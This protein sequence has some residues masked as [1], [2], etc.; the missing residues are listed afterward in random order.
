MKKTKFHEAKPLLGKLSDKEISL[1][2]DVDT[3]TVVRWRKKLNIKSTGI[4]F[5][6]SQSMTDKLKADKYFL[7]LLGNKPDNSIAKKFKVS[8]TLIMMIRNELNIKPYKKITK[9]QL[10]KTLDET[11]KE[12]IERKTDYKP[13]SYYDINCGWCA[14]FA[15]VVREKLNHSYQIRILADDDMNPDVEYSHT[16]IE[17]NDQYFDAECIEGVDDWTQLPTFHRN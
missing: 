1:T 14:D 15:T 16:F 10:I 8:H 2:F 3:S 9:K 4:R 11:R 6:L 12:F 13:K 7:S 17:F 5:K